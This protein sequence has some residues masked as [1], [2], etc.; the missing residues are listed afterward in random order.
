MMQL[1][2]AV[3]L[4][5][6]TAIIFLPKIAYAE[7]PLSELQKQRHLFQ[8]AREALK[9]NQHHYYKRVAKKLTDYPLYPY[10]E[11]WDINRKL[12]SIKTSRVNNFLS[13]YSDLPLAGRLRARWLTH[14]AKRNRWQTFIDFYQ[15]STNT[16]MQ[17][18]YRRALYKTG[19]KEKALNNLEELWLR[20]SSQPKAC[21]PLFAVWN[22]A[23]K[24]TP[25]LAWKR[26]ELAM[27]NN[28][29][30]LARYL[31]R[32]LDEPRSKQVQLWRQAHR[33]PD[34]HL[35][36]PR[37]RKDTPTNRA[38]LAHSVRRMTRRNASAAATAW[39]KLVM[40]YSFNE[41]QFNETESHIAV[42]LAR[43]GAPE[44]MHWLVNLADEQD[45]QVQKWRILTALN[46]EKW[47]DALHW[48]DQLPVQELQK[49]SWLYWR[50]RA[51]QEE[52]KQ[53]RADI[54]FGALAQKR[55]Y[56]GFLAADQLSLSY[57][58]ED[59][60]LRFSNTDIRTLGQVPEAQR[61][62]EFYAI[63]DILNAR[64]EWYALTQ[65]L[66]TQELPKA[67]QLAHQWGWHDRAIFTLGRAKYMDDLE[68]RFPLAHKEQ[69]VS[70]SNKQN[71]DPSWSYAVIR[72]ESAFASDARSPKGAMGLMQIMPTTGDSIAKELR[73]K[74]RNKHQLLDVDTNIRFGV[75]Y[76]RKVFNRFDQN[77]VLATAA[78]NAGS[79]RVKSWQPKE[80]ELASD[81]WIE[82]VPFK[83]TRNYLKQVLA[84]AAIYD[85]R[86]T[87]PIVSLKKRMP[88]IHPK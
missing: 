9:S 64:R 59:Y 21:D 18:Y 37:L 66:P 3:Q 41:A 61:A 43:Q 52:G 10:L 50:A 72:Q 44:A 48:L 55:S 47:S 39:N 46:Q 76:L 74:L 69:V 30:Y 53:Q 33:R 40:N 16:E 83:E 57:Q 2:R 19:N 84:Y 42:A 81:L 31:E 60:P 4:L 86:L 38:I 49:N 8:S 54:F 82:N 25:D 29:S 75:N 1:N 67:A 56:Y 87:K 27:N 11:Y 65:K 88:S 17:C 45:E 79:Q 5:V 62:R 22:E 70:I 14:L 13:T 6:L 15:T 12:S 77:T 28:Q 85:K 71:I 24:L 51:L 80:E 7:I 26:A 78:Y 36:D 35:T 73:T 63:G 32:F 20:G 34:K 23:G 68:I 58:F